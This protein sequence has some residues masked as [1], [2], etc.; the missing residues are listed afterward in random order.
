MTLLIDLWDLAVGLGGLLAFVVAI[1]A[2]TA[3]LQI[4]L[5]HA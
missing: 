1:L 2:T 4:A 5:E 3:A